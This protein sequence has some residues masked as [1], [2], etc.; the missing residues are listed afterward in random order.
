VTVTVV[1]TGGVVVA[2]LLTSAGVAEASIAKANNTQKA[3]V[4]MR[5]NIVLEK[6]WVYL[7]ILSKRCSIL[8]RGDCGWLL[9][10]EFGYQVSKP[11][12]ASVDTEWFVLA[13]TS[14]RWHSSKNILMT[15]FKASTDV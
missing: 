6:W 7:D 13:L 9:Y 15:C 14:V 5:E 1:V 4:E 11:T 10:S 3:I 12:Y 8:E 2:H